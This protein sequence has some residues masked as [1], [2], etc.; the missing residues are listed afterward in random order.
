MR[1]FL[2]EAAHNELLEAEARYD[3][4]DLL[5][6]KAFSSEV[7]EALDEI[8][9]HPRRSPIFGSKAI[10]RRLL[11]GLPYAIIYEIR[12]DHIRVLAIMHTSRRPGYWRRR[13]TKK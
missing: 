4:E 5:L 7:I 2:S 10:R 13:V 11:S 12:T 1:W 8:S 6:G 3:L 9:L